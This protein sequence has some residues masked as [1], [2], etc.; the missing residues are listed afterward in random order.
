LDTLH[1]RRFADSDF[2]LGGNT[3]RQRCSLTCRR[4]ISIIPFLSYSVSARYFYTCLYSFQYR[5]SNRSI[6]FLRL[7]HQLCANKEKFNTNESNKRTDLSA[8]VY[9]IYC[10]SGR[11]IFNSVRKNMARSK[12]F[13]FGKYRTKNPT[14]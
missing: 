1:H 3:F 7:F 13:F 9:F 10:F 8:S 4:R 6:S 12:F 11:F 5:L 14:F 2:Y